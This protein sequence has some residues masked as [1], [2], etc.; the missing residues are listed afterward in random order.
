MT[1]EFQVGV[2]LRACSGVRVQG[3]R[4]VTSTLGD[5]PSKREVTDRVEHPA[6]VAY[7]AKGKKYDW[8][9]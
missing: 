4:A 3:D 1:E 6:G 8:A 9:R 2:Q 5:G 7:L